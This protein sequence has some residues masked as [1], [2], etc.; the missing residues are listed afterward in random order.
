[1]A[2]AELFDVSR[3]QDDNST[4][5]MVNFALALSRG[6]VGAF[7]KVSQSTWLDCDYVMNWAHARDAG[8]PRS[9]FH[10]LDWTTSLANQARFFCGVISPDRG[11]IPP[12]LVARVRLPG[13]G[14]NQRD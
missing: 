10:F 2:Y 12:V 4:P 6:I 8:M 14:S 11:E 5:Q 13:Q 1:M 7:I 9:G 3:W